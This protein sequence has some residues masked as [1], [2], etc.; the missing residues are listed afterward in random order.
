MADDIRLVI[1]VDDR[2]LI[3]TQKEQKK[4]ERNLLT[5]ESA[6]RKGDITAKRYTSELNK[7]A[8]QLSGLGGSYNKANSEVRKYAASLR[9]ATDDQL[10]MT[11]ATNMAG[12]S[13]NRFG[14]Y[15]QQVGYQVGDFFVQVQSG[16]SALVAFGQQGTQLAGLLPGLAGAILG[17]GLSVG[18]MLLRTFFQ[19]KDAANETSA[20]IKAF[21]ES[22]KSA[23]EETASMAQELLLLE[24]GFTGV[25]E[26]A[27]DAA[28]KK[29]KEAVAKAQEELTRESNFL[30]EGFDLS[31]PDDMEDYLDL[32]QDYTDALQD[33]KDAQKAAEKDYLD[34]RLSQ[35]ALANER[36]KAYIS[37]MVDFFRQASLK[38]KQMD[39]KSINERSNAVARGIEIFRAAQK[40]MREEEQKT[41]DERQANAL[42]MIQVFRD[43]QKRI[44]DEQAATDAE[45]AKGYANSL[46]FSK[47]LT[48][49]TDAYVK[50]A[51]EGF[52]QTEKLKE[53]LGD[54]AYEALRLAGVDMK[55][56][57][58]AAALSAANLAADLN[59]S[60]AAALAMQKM[61]SNEDAVMSQAVVKGEAT[62]R[63]DVDTL[64]G[65]GY[66][67]EYLKL[68][69]K[70][71]DK[72]GGGASKRESQLEQF[73]SSLMTER[74][75][76]EQWRTE[77]LDF[78]GKYNE[79][80]LEVLGGHAEAKLRIE[81][82]YQDKRLA[83]IGQSTNRERDMVFDSGIQIL[84]AIGQFSDKALKIAR[85]ASAAK[86]LINTYEGASEALKL[87]F[88]ANIAAA[89][90]V[91]SAGLGFVAAIKSGSSSSGAASGAAATMPTQAAAATPQR[92]II[93]GIDRNSLFSGEQL[94]NIFEAIYE[95]NE[96][97]GMVFEVAR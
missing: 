51:I 41:R 88:P 28:V 85:V 61:A 71:K 18:T 72:T 93:E 34:F 32:I 52:R 56:G 46:G 40:R 68:I 53:Q 24:G 55:S 63:Y 30:L 89:A 96:N 94:S 77:Q 91:V 35:Q 60:L 54:A 79:S 16:T 2:D 23:K 44:R 73:I 17:I 87:P 80:E 14:M 78:L 4:F 66:T 76:L 58:D 8:K 5:I 13:T 62:D 26:A 49:E 86:A 6:L 37:E 31:N 15:A 9:K 25:S 29:T 42:S 92:V 74:E 19:A 11:Q 38:N 21:E 81:Q 84:N 57:I 7:Q 33:A 45:I 97:R 59:I 10:R 1:G 75:T 27:L 64:L 69:G 83:L 50:S 43:A 82:E 39:E 3:R 67:E 12:K 65:M 47:Q 48:N 36:G 22:L 95:E 70:I 20:S 90:S